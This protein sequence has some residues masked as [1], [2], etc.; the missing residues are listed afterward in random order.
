MAEYV[1]KREKGIVINQEKDK[2]MVQELLDLKEK[3]DK[4]LAQRFENNDKFV[5]SLKVLFPNSINQH[6]NMPA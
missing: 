4:T 2:T 1:K 5:N 3:F 6:Q